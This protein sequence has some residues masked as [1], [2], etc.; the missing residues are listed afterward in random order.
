VEWATNFEKWKE[1]VGWFQCPVPGGSWFQVRLMMIMMTS[2][3]IIHS[4]KVF[5]SFT[6]LSPPPLFIL[7]L[8]L[9]KKGQKFQQYL[10]TN[11]MPPCVSKLVI[12][13]VK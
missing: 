2:Q 4:L 11:H 7:L 9:H 6:F 10:L 5:R 12:D 8:L 1:K 3:E 13:L